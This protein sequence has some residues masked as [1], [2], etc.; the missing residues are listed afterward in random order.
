MLDSPRISRDGR[1][2]A[3]TYVCRL[4][5]LYVVDGLK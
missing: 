2:C 4:D 5:A 1:S 3:Y